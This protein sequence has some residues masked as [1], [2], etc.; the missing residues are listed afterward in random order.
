VILVTGCAGFI[1]SHLCDLLLNSQEKVIGIDNLSTGSDIKNLPK[2]SNFQFFQVDIEKKR[3]ISEILHD[4]KVE[5]IVHLAAA[6]HVDRSISNPVDF[7][8]TNVF[9]TTV[10]LNAAMRSRYLKLFVNQV[11][12]EVFGP[13][14]YKV[15]ETHP[16]H[17]TSPYAASKASQC[18]IGHS[19][20][21]T[22]KMPIISTFPTNTFGPRQYPEKI[23]PKFIQ[24]LLNGQKVPLMQSSHFSRDWLAVSDHVK[25]LYFLIQQGKP[26]EDYCISGGNVFTNLNL[27]YNLLS[28]LNKSDDSI[29]IVPDRLSHDSS[30]LV[31]D[32]Q[33]RSLGWK[34]K[35]DF[36]GYLKQ[37]VEW[38]C[39]NQARFK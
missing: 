17:P 29:E 27:T 14:T 39:A 15:N 7:V 8:R 3:K 21:D 33:I 20:R 24:K 6:S 1:G 34:P 22:Y 4:F 36:K 32:Y 2:S 23:I 13:T 12:D 11:T 19:F 16:L 30:Y 25:A 38:Y 10:L 35:E 37:T 5:V 28:L 26:G 31:D 9:G 18:L